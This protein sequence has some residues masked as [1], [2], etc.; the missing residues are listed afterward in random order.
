[1]HLAGQVVLLST[2]ADIPV[3]WLTKSRP[4]DMTF[5]VLFGVAVI[6]AAVSCG[7]DEPT[8]I[9]AG[10]RM[11]VEEQVAIG[12]AL[13]KAARALDSTHR[14]ADAVLADWI[15]IGAGLVSRQG[16]H[17]RMSVRVQPRGGA[18]STLDM[19]GVSVRVNEGSARIHLVLAWEGLDVEQ[20]RAQ[21]VLMLL[22]SGTVE[23]GNLPG[24]GGT[25]EGRWID[26]T[27]GAAFPDPY[28]TTTGTASVSGGAFAGGCPGVADTEQF[29]CTT[30]RQAVLGD[31]TVERSGQII[32]IVWDAVVLPSF[33]IVGSV[34]DP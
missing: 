27:S 33:R 32:D 16:Q 24:A 13:E 5:R 26:F 1:M 4:T 29:T 31:V 22:F 28:L 8:G 20:L 12:S 10:E 14:A 21:R 6:L 18:A 34:F 9:T 3:R 23:E 11:T 30:G 25:V 15:R 7:D 2:R 17:G 19:R